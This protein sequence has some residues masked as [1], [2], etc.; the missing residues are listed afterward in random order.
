MT[1]FV[2]VSLMN[3][4]QDLK[5]KMDLILDYQYK[6][7]RP[8]LESCAEQHFPWEIEICAICAA[9]FSRLVTIFM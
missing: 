4:S 2:L 3:R 6:Y 9:I 7:V 1:I 5:M 8:Q